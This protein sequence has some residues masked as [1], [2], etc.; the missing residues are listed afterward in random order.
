MEV[1]AWEPSDMTGVP[2]KIIEHS[3]NVNQSLEPFCQKRRTF[4][5]EK[6]KVVTN[7][8]AEWVRAGIV[9]P[10]KYPTYISNPVLVKKCDGS[11]RMCIDFKILNSACPKDYYSLPSID[12]KVEAVMGFKYKCFFDAYKVPSLPLKS[13]VYH[14]PS[15]ASVVSASVVDR[16]IGIDNPHLSLG[17]QADLWCIEHLRW[18]QSTGCRE[19]VTFGNRGL[20]PPVGFYN[21]FLCWHNAIPAV[22]SLVLVADSGWFWPIGEPTMAL[23]SFWLS[24][25]HT[26]MDRVGQA[27][28][29][30]LNLVYFFRKHPI[31]H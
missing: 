25:H 10:V 6:S 29:I 23:H 31:A 21:Y 16:S 2:R 15:V 5:P 24:R 3:L 11:W 27:T 20:G 7:K 17:S 14:E 4:S 26:A 8:V 30:F 1:F 12:C 28:D 9:R 19:L 13:P 18:Y 22:L